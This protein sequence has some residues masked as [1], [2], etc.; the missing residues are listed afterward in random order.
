MLWSLHI[1][2]ARANWADRA[3]DVV[4]EL[5]DVGVLRAGFT[6]TNKM[7]L[8]SARDT[9]EERIKVCDNVI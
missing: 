1:G 8:S 4:E 7:G 9:S 2:Q 6:V 5:N 3:R